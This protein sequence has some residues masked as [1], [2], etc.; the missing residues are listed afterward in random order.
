M[1][2]TTLPFYV[3]QNLQ[4]FSAEDKLVLEEH[5]LEADL[6]WSLPKNTWFTSTLHCYIKQAHIMC[7]SVQ[8]EKSPLPSCKQTWLTLGLSLSQSDTIA[9]SM[10]AVTSQSCCFGPPTIL[11]SSPFLNIVASGRKDQSCWMYE[12]SLLS[13]TDNVVDSP[14]NDIQKW[15]WEYDWLC[16]HAFMNISQKTPLMHSHHFLGL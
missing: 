14:K 10:K 6:P 12:V 8:T 15:R 4:V 1:C 5:N 16:G 2:V 3:Y 9:L 13:G 7:G 11:L